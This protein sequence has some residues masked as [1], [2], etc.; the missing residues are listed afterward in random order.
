MVDFILVS[1]YWGDKKYQDFARRFRKRC[2]DLNIPHYIKY[3]PRFK[4]KYQEGINYKPTFILNMLDKF[5]NKNVVYLDI[6]I[7]INKYPTLF[8][9]TCADFMCFNWNF[10]PY[11]TIDDKIDPYTVETAGGIF[12]FA[13]NK[14][15]R[16]LLNIWKKAL[17]MKT[18][19]YSAD[20]RV[21]AMQIHKHN[22]VDKL[23]VQYIPTEYLY[24]PQFFSKLRLGKKAVFIHD[25]DI[26]S[27][28]QAK[29]QDKSRGSR[30]PRSYKLHKIT[31]DHSKK[32]IFDQ[33]HS[34]L[35]SRLKKSGFN[36]KTLYSMGNIRLR[37]SS[38]GFVHFDPETVT[39]DDILKIWRSHQDKCDVL[40]SKKIQG[41][42][43][44]AD[45]G[46][47]SFSNHK[48]KLDTLH[49]KLF[50]KKNRLNYN[51]IYE[52]K[53]CSEKKLSGLIEIFN[54]NVSYSLQNRLEKFK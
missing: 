7:Y 6:D 26:T 22:I 32:N 35:N 28:E 20:D 33:G 53:K 3:I 52:W 39:A 31:Q 45:I 23:R 49:T 4:G 1:Y 19:K 50:L 46:S 42:N 17:K 5:P 44:G 13:N 12:Y 21:L 37:C 2:K 40:I 18:Y 24:I 25:Q 48:L 8:K 10:D 11:V 16:Y 36:F 54:N 41:I 29:L 27:E 47:N 34:K 14:H 30:I 51:M 38:K 15:S 9:K 43:C